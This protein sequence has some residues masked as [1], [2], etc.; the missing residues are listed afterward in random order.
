[1]KKLL[2]T[3]AVDILLVSISILVFRE[4]SFFYCGIG[5]IWLGIVLYKYYN[6]NQ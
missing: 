4:D 1:M 6:A 2:I 5:I 3:I